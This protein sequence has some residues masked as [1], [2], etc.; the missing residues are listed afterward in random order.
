MP[1]VSPLTKAQRLLQQ[2]EQARK[3]VQRAIGAYKAESKKSDEQLSDD[4]KWDRGRLSRLKAS[5][6]NSKLR[7]VKAVAQKVG[8]TADDWLRIGG[9]LK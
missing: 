8:L 1:R 2:D 7:D 4:L 9:F 6:S 3:I 5:P